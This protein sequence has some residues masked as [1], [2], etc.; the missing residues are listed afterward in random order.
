MN[1]P[2]AKFILGAYRP[3]GRDAGDPMFAGALSQAEHEPELHA[4]FES[5]RKFDATIAG[6][7]RDVAPPAELREAILA[8]VR[9][10]Q[11]RRHWWTNP[12]WLAAAAAIVVL[13]AVTVTVVPSI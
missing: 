5:Q 8:G 11:P 2:E 9:A 3:D 7:L 4:W 13:A 1:N 10:S 6:K 12:A